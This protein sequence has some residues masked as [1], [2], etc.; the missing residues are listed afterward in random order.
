M[1]EVPKGDPKTFLSFVG[2]FPPDDLASL[3]EAVEQD[4]LMEWEYLRKREAEE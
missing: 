2:F 3:K 4:A 1:T